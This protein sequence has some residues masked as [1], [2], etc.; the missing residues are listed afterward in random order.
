MEGLSMD[1][2]L[3]HVQVHMPFHLLY[4]QFLPMVI[5]KRINPE[6]SFNH[7]SLDRFNREDFLDVAGR[8]LDAGLTITFHAPFMDLRPGAIDP[9]IRQVTIDRLKQ[10]FDLVPFFR[11]LSVVCHPS[12]D[13]KYYVSSERLWLEN[14]LDTWRQ[15]LVVAGE[16]DTM[17]A[18]ENVYESDT[19][20]FSLILHHLPSPHLC[21]CFDTG[22]FNVFS[23]TPLNVWMENLGSRMGQIHVHDNKGVL[24][25]H[26]PVGQGTFP[27]QDFFGRVR[28]QD[29]DPI[30][31][32]ES[33]TE[34][35]LWQML[36]NIKSMDL[37][38]T[39]I[40][41]STELPYASG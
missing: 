25:E 37:L 32:L 8:L 13:R 19:Q 30:I 22:H 27:F 7:T 9:G 24:D 34:N 26:L 31:T 1:E 17:I 3:R 20:P 35:D 12:F 28:E 15:F 11:P 10:V 39:R 23:E 38:R 18:L 4:S 16:M 14:S 40:Y 29:R 33:H 6:I 41:K 21:F 2:I 36:G 5:R